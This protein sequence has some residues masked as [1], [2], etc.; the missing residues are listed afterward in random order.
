[1]TN[2]WLIRVSET[3]EQA[4]ILFSINQTTDEE[5]LVHRLMK[6]MLKAIRQYSD[7]VN[8]ISNN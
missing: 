5:F 7:S 2:F 1:M 3:T 6:P 4:I 8:E